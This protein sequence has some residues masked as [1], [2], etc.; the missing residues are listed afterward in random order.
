MN[1]PKG[2]LVSSVLAIWLVPAT[3]VAQKID[4]LE[5]SND[6]GDK[7]VF[8]WTL[9]NKAQQME[10]VFNDFGDAEIRGVITV[11]GKAYELVVEKSPVKLTVK[12]GLCLA[13]GQACTFAPGLLLLDMPL[14]KG[15]KWTTSF[16]VTGDTFVA[17]LT[18][19]R[20]VDGFEKVRV[21]AGEYDAVKISFSARIV[22]KSTKGEQY[23]GKEEGTEWWSFSSGRPIPTK[24]VYRN[25]FGEKFTRELISAT[26]K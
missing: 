10:E 8:K 9:G 4:H 16:T 20:K 1:I 7:L 14:E 3:V 21:P 13:N 19:E 5:F 25:S 23:T 26:L 12:K 18:Q 2:L 6:P 11:G 15:K 17:E 24:V 22:S